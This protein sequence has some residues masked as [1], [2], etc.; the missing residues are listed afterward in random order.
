MAASRSAARAAAAAKRILVLG[1]SGAGK[2][3]F[4]K[5]LC[6]LLQISPIHLDALFWQPGWTPSHQ[7]E[8]RRRVTL[9][10]EREAWIMDGTY[11]ASLDLRLPS[12]QSIIYI[13]A[14]RYKCLWRALTR[15]LRPS[16]RRPPESPLG[17]RIDF[18]L[19]RYIWRFPAV[20]KSQ[21]LSLIREYGKEEQF[22]V[23][24]GPRQVTQFLSYVRSELA[25]S[26]NPASKS[27]S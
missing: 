17:Q 21:I 18:G 5:R 16:D 14:S 8:W 22:M 11:E 4:T 10:V 9:L 23:L 7:R 24:D 26:S 1:S 13:E 6:A 15:A 27:T 25:D 12:A 2:S 19:V 20:T 3:R